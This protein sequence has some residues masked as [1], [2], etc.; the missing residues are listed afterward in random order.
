MKT[1][2]VLSTLPREGPSVRPRV[3]AY[4]AALR[5][6][7]IRMEFRPFLS[8][9]VFRSFYGLRRSDR[10][11]KVAGSL[12]AY[13]RRAALLLSGTGADGVLVHR[14]VVPRGN[15]L[16]LSALRRGR[17]LVAYDLD[18]A[19][20]LAP[21]DFVGEGEAS[22]AR[23][24]RLK[25]PAETDAL[26]AGAD[27]VL[28]GNEEI[29]AHAR[30]LNGRVRV[31]PTVVDTDVFRPRPR[32]ARAR[33]LVGWI[34]SPTAAYCLKA[35]VPAL[36]RAAAEAPFDL[37]VAGAGEPI[38][39]PGVRVVEAPWS[40][41]SESEL[42]ASLDVGLYPLPDNPW[43]RG[44][45][46]MKAIQYLSCGVAAVVSPVG[47]N[48]RIVAHGRTGT[49]ARSVEEWTAALL[50]Y[51]HDPALRAEHGA[52]GRA[53]VEASWSLRAHA[54]AFVA[55]VREVLR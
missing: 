10:A 33:P 21:R 27:I 14:E 5:E 38:E 3:L 20:Y 31:Q 41:S 45:C 26:L 2:L 34:G 49:L 30:T 44:K 35:I 39:V 46:G 23:M 36:A 9:A 7:G 22:R 15:P 32:E 40:V 48:S 24:S 51:L 25:S 29:A 53:A 17:R 55:A 6:S 1:L 18:D 43:T 16:C 42:F 37:L 28:A 19:L 4:E 52:A 11:I 50:R 54:P 47:V 13:L 8:P 12:A